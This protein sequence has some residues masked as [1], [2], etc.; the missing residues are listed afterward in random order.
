MVPSYLEGHFKGHSRCLKGLYAKFQGASMCAGAR[1]IH[2]SLQ[3]GNLRSILLI[4]WGGLSPNN[5]PPLYMSTP[6][7]IVLRD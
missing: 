4:Q 2:S 3:P 1:P 5:P 6:G 7:F